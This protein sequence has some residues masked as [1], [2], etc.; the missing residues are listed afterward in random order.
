MSNDLLLTDSAGFA[1]RPQ[2]LSVAALNRLARETLEASIPLLWVAGE[3][4]NLTRASSGHLYFT[5]KD[6]QAQVRCTMWRN[7]AQLL[8]FRPENGMRVEARALVTLYEVRGDYQLSIEALRPAGVGNL[9]EAFNRLK[10]K[11]ANEGL[12]DP[13]TRRPLPRHPRGVGIVTSPAAAALQDVLSTLRRRAAHLD[14]VLYP[15]PVQGADAAARL[16]AAVIQAGARAMADGVDVLLLVRGGGSIEDLWSFNDEALARA[17]RACPVPV[18]SGVGHETDFTI[19]DFASD[20]RAPTPTG[21]A[22]LVTSGYVAAQQTVTALAPRLQRAVGRKLETLSQRLDRSALRLT[23]PQDRL[24]RAATDLSSLSQRLWAAL[25]RSVEKKRERHAQLQLRL[26][27]RQPEIALARERCERLAQRLL[28]SA[29]VLQRRRR[30]QLAALSAHLLHLAPE[31]V[32][33]RGYS[34]A[35]D[36][37]GNILRSVGKLTPGDAIEIELAHGKVDAKVLA[38]RPDIGSPPCPEPPTGP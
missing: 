15:S 26:T 27:S 25:Q 24:R 21:A 16:T 22:E 12:F 2:V 14:V 3:I 5:L 10:D 33:A 36:G 4:S 32:L 6:E 17:I 1:P 7:R 13:A 19:A 11:L 37:K 20:L 8:A 29:E 9:Y 34:I 23:H 30:E 38:A 31:A 18:I 35:R 28:L